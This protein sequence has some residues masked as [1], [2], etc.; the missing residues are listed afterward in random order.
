M[1]RYFFNIAHPGEPSIPDEEGEQL[2]DLA[3]A[4]Q[5]AVA[6]LRDL[7]ADAA[8][9]G[10]TVNGLA[11]QIVDEGGKVLDAVHARLIFDA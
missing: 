6:S 8:K 1:P 9:R 2:E 5:E 3:A 10:S 7:I 4:R 11:I